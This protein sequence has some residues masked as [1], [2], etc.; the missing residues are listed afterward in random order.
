MI[1]ILEE[2]YVNYS[3][4][5]LQCALPGQ[6]CALLFIFQNIRRTFGRHYEKE[7]LPLFLFCT[8]LLISC[9][10]LF[11]INVGYKLNMSGQW[12]LHCA[13]NSVDW[14]QFASVGG[15]EYRPHWEI[16]ACWGKRM[17]SC[18]KRKYTTLFTVCDLVHEF[19]FHLCK[20]HISLVSK[21]DQCKYGKLSWMNQLYDHK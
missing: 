3:S 9:F 11:R 1:K 8:C 16:G 2:T 17:N 6:P 10:F 19:Q 15:L 7:S 4:C 21:L 20:A 12:K 18:P 14:Q 5:I 13:L